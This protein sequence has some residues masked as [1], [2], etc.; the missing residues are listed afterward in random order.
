[1][2]QE[3]Q[4]PAVL[5]LL[6]LKTILRTGWTRHPIPAESLESVADHSYGVTLLCWMLCPPELDRLRVLE[7]A[8]LHDLAEVETGDLTPHDGVEQ[9]VKE[10]REKQVLAQLLKGLPR[11]Q[12]GGE[13]L[14]EYQSQTT[15]EGR[16]VRQVDKLEMSLQSLVYERS[17]GSDLSEFRESSAEKLRQLGFSW[18]APSS[19]E[20]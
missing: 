16:F 5:N 13:L 12:L 9:Y 7:L 14:Q 3:A 19:D 4:L 11:A 10:E 2:F 6:G 15:P 8:I 20:E 18:L 17:T 1:M